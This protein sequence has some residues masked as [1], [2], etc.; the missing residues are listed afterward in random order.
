MVAGEQLLLI[1]LC[2]NN[3]FLP[4][5]VVERHRVRYVELIGCDCAMAE[6]PHD[7][8]LFNQCGSPQPGT[9]ALLEGAG[10]Q[11]VRY[12]FH[13]LR[14]NLDE[15]PDFPLPDGLEVRPARP[16]E[17]R[18]IWESTDDP[19]HEEW[20]S[21]ELTEDGYQ[22]WVNSPLFQPELW[23][24]AWDRAGGSP[25][26]HVLTFIDHD[27]NEQSDRKRGYTEGRCREW[28]RRGGAGL[29]SRSLKAKRSR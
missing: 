24:I 23:Q 17:Y 29:I 16:D 8:K 14:P 28:R 4:P 13:M 19:D 7:P 15:L 6:H 10:Y 5:G 26:G 25:V 3:C 21:P 11:A 12:F 1:V 22:E 27:E 18:A 20:G 2:V 9:T